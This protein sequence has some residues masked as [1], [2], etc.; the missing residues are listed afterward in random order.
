MNKDRPKIIWL[1]CK[2]MYEGETVYIRVPLDKLGRRLAKEM[3][4]HWSP[5]IACGTIK[6]YDCL[7]ALLIFSD[8]KTIFRYRTR[9]KN[10]L[11]LYRDVKLRNYAIWRKQEA[12]RRCRGTD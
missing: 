7:S 5:G 11:G 3:L 12:I 9:I 2:F 6:Y 8:W 4:S 1:E 10:H